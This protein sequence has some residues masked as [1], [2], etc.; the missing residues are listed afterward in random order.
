MDLIETA[1]SEVFLSSICYQLGHKTAI[2]DA[3]DA[4]VQEQREVLVAQGLAYCRVTRSSAIEL[5][6]ASARKTMSGLG[7]KTVDAVVYCT[8]TAPDKSVTAD[9]WDL[10]LA[11]DLPTTPVTVV[12]GSGC[13]NLGPGLRLARSLL[14]EGEAETVLLVT[15]DRVKAGTRYL[16]NG[17]TV[18]S[19]GAAS[20]LVSSWKPA[21]GF[22]LLG[23][24]SSSRLDIGTA[25]L[26]PILVAK[27][28][29]EAVRSA[30]ER[31]IRPMSLSR[32]DFQHLLPGYYG[33][34]PQ[35]FLAMSAGFPLDKIYCPMLPDVGHCFSADVLLSL[36]S[37]TEAGGL[38]SGDLLMLLAISPRSW[39]VAP[40]SYVKLEEEPR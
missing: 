7:D 20:C 19:D 25:K 8:D 35:A 11:L 37:L 13:G 26:R 31:S 2:A 16:G 18:L 6:A 5:G 17:Q 12:G 30:I 22:H 39:S 10:L 40:V 38:R 4:S 27:S 32:D 24:A 34:S 14:S 3:G 15:A 1:S 23:L 33:R 29:A 36:A 9:A 21:S 28:T